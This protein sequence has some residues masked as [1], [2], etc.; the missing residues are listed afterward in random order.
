MGRQERHVPITHLVGL[1]FGLEDLNEDETDHLRWCKDCFDR[2][3]E[4]PPNT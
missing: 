2:M 1:M 3:L 4:E